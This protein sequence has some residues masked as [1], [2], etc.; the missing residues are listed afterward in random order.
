[1]KDDA[2]AYLA[3]DG[4]LDEPMLESAWRTYLEQY[5]RPQPSKNELPT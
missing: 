3:T 1:V 2:A 4:D 5:A